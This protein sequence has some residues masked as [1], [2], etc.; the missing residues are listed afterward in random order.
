IGPRLLATWCALE[1]KKERR[2]IDPWSA[3]VRHEGNDLTLHRAEKQVWIDA[4]HAALSS[5]PPGAEPLPAAPSQ[6]LFATLEPSLQIFIAAAPEDA[7]HSEQLE[8]HLMPLVLGGCVETWSERR[9]VAGEDWKER[10]AAALDEAAIIVVL[11]SADLIA[12][13]F[14]RE[15]MER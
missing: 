6:A 13:D 12:S 10:L 5:A 3:W 2:S 11:I 1:L 8:R 9:V 4:V 14:R 7:P 15:Q